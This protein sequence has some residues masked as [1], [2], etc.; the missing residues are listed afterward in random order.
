MKT[1]IVL[2][3]LVL[4]SSATALSLSRPPDVDEPLPNES[5]E[6]PSTDL[7]GIEIPTVV[8]TDQGAPLPGFVRKGLSWLAEA[9]Q[10]NGGW[11]GGSHAN[12]QNIDPHEVP[13]DPGT[14]AFTAMAFLRA[15]HTVDAGVYRETVKR[16]TDYLLALAEA[17]EEEG[18][19]ITE[20]VGTQP[21]AKMGPFVDTALCAQFFSRSLKEVDAE[22]KLGR[23]LA[24]ARDK[25]LRKIEAAQHEDGS[26]GRGGWAPVLQ[27]SLMSNALELGR[28]TGGDVGEKSLKRAQEY[29]MDQ[30]DVETG[31]IVADA[32]AGI[33]LY[34]SAGN[35]RAVAGKAKEAENLIAEAKKDGRVDAAAPIDED[36]LV[37]A[38]ASREEAQLMALGY[39]QGEAAKSRAFDD[40]LLQGF[41]NNGGEEFLSYLM[42]SESL[43]IDGGAEWTAWNDK[44]H[45]RLAKI[46]NG[47]GSWSG[48][49]CI[50]SPVFCTAAVTLCLT[51][52]R[53]A[54]LL[55]KSAEAASEK[56]LSVDES[57]EGQDD[58]EDDGED[59]A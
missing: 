4:A 26:W 49:H 38:G 55:A 52:D 56:P 5:V 40:D 51:A 34:A 42:N 2:S 24:A 20:I 9:Q 45:E 30:V 54:T 11:G 3:A 23:R 47:D 25:C 48:H 57:D 28:A 41:G 50:T 33:A 27:S 19:R 36:T 35:M 7:P 10:E 58:G 18:P 29:Q 17:A 16:A 22:S 13:T 53:D 37:A 32:A 44:M 31:A 15:G 39:L 21:Q 46:Q 14:S 12:Q 43:V 1:K 8:V 59:D 6:G